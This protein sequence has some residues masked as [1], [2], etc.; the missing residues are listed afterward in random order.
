MVKSVMKQHKQER[1]EK[2][3]VKVM[4]FKADVMNIDKYK[5]RH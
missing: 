4:N 1:R 3:K 5:L 2:C